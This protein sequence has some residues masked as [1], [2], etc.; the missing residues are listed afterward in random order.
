[1]PRRRMRDSLSLNL[2]LDGRPY[3]SLPV[4]FHHKLDDGLLDA[5][6]LGEGGADLLVAHGVVGPRCLDDLR[7]LL[8]RKVLP[9]NLGVQ[10]VVVQLENLVVGDGAGVGKVVRAGEA[11]KGAL[12]CHR[13]KLFQH[14]HGVGNVDNL[15]VVG[16]LG[17]EVPRVLEIPVD[18]HA[19]AA[20]HHVGVVSEHHLHVRFGLR[21]ERTPKVGVVLLGERDTSD[22][23]SAVVLVDATGGKNW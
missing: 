4:W 7:L 8:L 3:S 22:G 17:D 5:E 14:R 2:L 9:R 13:D 19:H 15:G 1:M 21:V 6:H 16:N 20:L 11:A 10:V 23:V 18:G 12:D